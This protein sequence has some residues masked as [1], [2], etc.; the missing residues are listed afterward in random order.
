MTGQCA[1]CWA[2]VAAEP[3]M[4]PLDQGCRLCPGVLW[5]ARWHCRPIT[6]PNTPCPGNGQVLERVA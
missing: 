5:V 2:L 1:R 6:P 4:G 3:L